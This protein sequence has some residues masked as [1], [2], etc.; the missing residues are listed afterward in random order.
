MICKTPIF[1]VKPEDFSGAV[2]GY[3]RTNVACPKQI[4][5]LAQAALAD[6]NGKGKIEVYLHEH[7]DGTSSWDFKWDSSAGWDCGFEFSHFLPD[8]NGRTYTENFAV[9]SLEEGHPA[10]ELGF[11]YKEYGD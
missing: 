3:I 8:E 10:E 11:S 9:R 4:L 7:E 1:T 2:L 5:V 6:W